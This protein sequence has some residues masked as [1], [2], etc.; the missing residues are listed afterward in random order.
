M[1]H[2]NADRRRALLPSVFAEFARAFLPHDEAYLAGDGA[3]AALWAPGGVDAVGPDQAEAFGERL[4]A[5]VGD[6]AARV[7]EFDALLERHHPAEPCFYLQF[8]GA[9]PEQQGQGIGSRM[10]AA[11]L[12]R[13]DATGTP[14][15]LEATSQGN[16]RLYQRHGFA[17]A[18]EITLP[19]GPALWPM[20]R[21][22]GA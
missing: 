17:V 7:A 15:Y 20:W 21:E 1:G 18:G 4:A 8:L 6:D 19:R 11:V 12:P 10:L 9:M 14:A 2:P 16:R 5:I 13:C 22:P 3:G